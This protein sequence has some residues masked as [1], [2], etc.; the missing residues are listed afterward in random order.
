LTVPSGSADDKR[1]AE[2]GTSGTGAGQVAF[3]AY[4]QCTE[5]EARD[6]CRE[7]CDALNRG[8]LEDVRRR[9]ECDLEWRGPGREEVLAIGGERLARGYFPIEIVRL[10]VL[11]ERVVCTVRGQD[12]PN[13]TFSATLHEGKWTQVTD[14]AS[15]D[16]GV[17][18]D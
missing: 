8:D 17:H 11:R 18:G 16:R 15:H 10:D 9:L 3:L 14:E 12:G 5:D 2:F 1:H 4:D 6:L 13:R 7:T